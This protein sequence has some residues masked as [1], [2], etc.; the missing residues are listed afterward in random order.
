MSAATH[1]SQVALFKR[2]YPRGV[3]DAMAKKSIGLADCKKDSKW[4]G[5]GGYVNICIAGTTGGSASFDEALANQGPSNQ[6]RFFVQ[7]KTEYQIATVTGQ[8]IARSLDDKMAVVKV[9]KTETDK[10]LDMFNA[11]L[12]RRF[13]G[14]AGGAVG[15]ISAASNVGTNT[16]TF[17]IPTD[18]IGIRP[19][20]FI[21]TASDNGTAAAPAGLNG[22]GAKARVVSVD[23]IAGTVTLSAPWSTLI[24]GTAA[25]HFVFRSGDYTLAMTGLDGWLPSVD[26]TPGESFMG[27]DR[28]VGDIVLQSGI[29]H[30]GA[31]GSKEDALLDATAKAAQFESKLT[32]GY[33]NPL[34][35][36]DISKELGSKRYSDAKTREGVSGFQGIQIYTSNGVLEVVADPWVKR[37]QAKLVNPDDITLKSAGEVPNPLNLGGAQAQ[38]VLANADAL[39]FR[40]GCYGEFT[41]EMKNLPVHVNF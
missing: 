13:F 8:A 25:G 39:Q 10:A 6:K 31:G 34:D 7:H 5:E 38:Q 41:F 32:R 18:V 26:P 21:Q 27:M 33:V 35:F 19:G 23:P 29:R 1:A 2:M 9:L 30:N 3:V 11:A 20:Q 12:S 14:N 24:P 40:L 16:I 36:N 4:G 28:T 15:Q 37:G 17:A 22:A